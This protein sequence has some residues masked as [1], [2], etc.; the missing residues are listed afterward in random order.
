MNATPLPSL[1]VVLKKTRCIHTMSVG[2]PCARSAHGM[3]GRRVVSLL[4]GACRPLCLASSR[5]AMRRDEGHLGG[6]RRRLCWAVRGAGRTR[7]ARPLPE[8][9]TRRAV[10]AQNKRPRHAASASGLV[11]SG[12]SPA[13]RTL[14]CPGLTSEG[15]D[16]KANAI[17]QRGRRPLQSSY[18]TARGTPRDSSVRSG[19]TRREAG[20]PV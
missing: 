1:M 7:T 15:R 16:L 4:A 20:P 14:F 18:L 6:P 3:L 5:R 17:L 13:T 9:N 19:D 12:Y 10:G 8:S 11:A 2:V